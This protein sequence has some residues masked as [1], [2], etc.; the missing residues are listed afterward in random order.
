MRRDPIDHA[1][2]PFFADCADDL[3]GGRAAR[4]LKIRGIFRARSVA[5]RLGVL[6]EDFSAARKALLSLRIGEEAV[7]ADSHESLG[8]NVQQET[9]DELDGRQ[10]YLSRTPAAA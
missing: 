8:Q 2:P 9:S 6:A 3:A 5:A 4:H 10:S 1:H 7:A